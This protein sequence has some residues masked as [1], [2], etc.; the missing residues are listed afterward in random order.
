[1]CDGFNSIVFKSSPDQ[2]H[3]R[4]V[5]SVSIAQMPEQTIS[6]SEFMRLLNTFHHSKVPVHFLESMCWTYWRWGACKESLE[7][8]IC[9]LLSYNHVV[10]SYLHDLYYISSEE[11]FTLGWWFS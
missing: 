2:L 6:I 4:P 3:S 11:Q 8:C 10:S 7:A 5:Q 1:M 9:E